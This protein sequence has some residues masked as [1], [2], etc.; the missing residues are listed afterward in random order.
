MQI[1]DAMED[2]MHYIK[3]IDQ[4]ALT[5]IRSYEYQL[6]LYVSYLK[7]KGIHKMQEITYEDIQTFLKEQGEIKKKA[8]VNHITS[9]IR[10]FHRFI[11]YTYDHIP[12]PSMY[13]RNTKVPRTLPHYF[14]ME[15]M[16]TLFQSFTDS[17]IDIFHRAILEVLYG[18]GLRISE[19][20]SLTLHQI[21]LEQRFIR[22]I[23]KGDKERM[24]PIHKRA[25]KALEIYLHTLR[26]KW[27][28]KSI[29]VF[30]DHKGKQVT[31]QYVHT[32][33]KKR[34]ADLGLNQELSAHSFRHSFASHLLDGGADLRVVQELLG[35]ADIAT[36]QIYTHIQNK[37]LK[38]AYEKA[39]PRVKKEENHEK[40]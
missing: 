39:H 7:A 3:V 20:C 17:D 19:L 33:I 29:Y 18:C 37:R 13:I 24:I 10:N 14:N 30:I 26:V 32:M 35:H 6:Q 12:N 40:I 36:T 9:L 38:L 1:T 31:R 28:Q 25:V 22:C 21:H 15:D 4:K 16:Q 5:T 8:S 2:Y 11:S 27:G 23:G 34:L